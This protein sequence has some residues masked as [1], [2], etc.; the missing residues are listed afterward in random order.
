MIS[1]K[2]YHW[3]P[4]AV[5]AV[6]TLPPAAACDR[7]PAAA[8]WDGAIGGERREG[9]PAAERHQAPRDAVPVEPAEHR[10]GHGGRGRGRRRDRGRGRG[11]DGDGLPGQGSEHGD[12]GEGC[13]ESCGEPA[14]CAQA[15]GA[16]GAGDVGDGGC[17]DNGSPVAHAHAGGTPRRVLTLPNLTRPVP[18]RV[19][20]SHT[21]RS[22]GRAS[23]SRP[24]AARPAP[25]PPRRPPRRGSRAGSPPCRTPW[26][27]I[28]ATRR[29]AR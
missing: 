5:S 17:G 3:M 25:A 12:E 16:G 8:M 18:G 28:P 9:R 21:S 11:G 6:P 23:R 2:R 24:P 4:R 14:A 7:V 1:P 15:G 13:D 10:G 26:P 19:R 20:P 29:P 27:A 22:P